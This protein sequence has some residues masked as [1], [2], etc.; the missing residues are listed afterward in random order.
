MSNT[1]IGYNHSSAKALAGR[2][3][4]ACRVPQIR[5]YKQRN[6]DCPVTANQCGDKYNLGVCVM[7]LYNVIHW[8]CF[9]KLNQCFFI[10]VQVRC[11]RISR[12]ITAEKRRDCDTAISPAFDMMVVPLAWTGG[13]V[14]PYDHHATCSRTP[15]GSFSRGYRIP[16]WSF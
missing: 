9:R 3:L 13:C 14:S 16:F 12:E 10:A 2:E 5:A 15:A 1:R 8:L 4:P 7:P 6:T 11:L